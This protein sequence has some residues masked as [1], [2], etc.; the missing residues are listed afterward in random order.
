MYLVLYVECMDGIFLLFIRTRERYLQLV[1][2][3][4]M[5]GLHVCEVC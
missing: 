5:D 3:V 4:D 1:T 2:E